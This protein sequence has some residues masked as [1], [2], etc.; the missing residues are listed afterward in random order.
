MQNLKQRKQ[1]RQNAQPS[2][3]VK[4][5]PITQRVFPFYIENEYIRVLRPQVKI[6]LVLLA[7]T[8]M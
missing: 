3:I 6:K 7:S 5:V 8:R 1:K 2:L 4:F